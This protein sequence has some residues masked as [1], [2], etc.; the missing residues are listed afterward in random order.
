MAWLWTLLVFG[1]FWFWIL[2]A[3]EVFC[4]FVCIA[5]D[6]G[7]PATISVIV[8]A[9]LMALFGGPNVFRFARDH[10]VSFSL[11]VGGYIVAGTIWAIVKWWFFVRKVR[12]KYDDAKSKFLK[13]KGFNVMVIPPEL[14]EDWRRTIGF[15]FGA[16]PQARE[17][18]G[19]ILFWMTFWPFSLTWTLVDDVITRIFEEIY[20]ALHSFL[21]SISNRAFRGIEND[22]TDSPL[23]ASDAPSPS[24]RRK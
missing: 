14:R 6:R 21:Q 18:K 9:T 24:H 8:F 4:L 2:A 15:G 11:W 22:L 3:G 20:E 5:K 12:R 23:N 13:G 7:T 16:P 10:P 17:H 1:G 19:D